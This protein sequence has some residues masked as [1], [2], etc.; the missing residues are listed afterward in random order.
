[1][2]TLWVSDSEGMRLKA[3]RPLLKPTKRWW[4]CE[5]QSRSGHWLMIILSPLSP[6]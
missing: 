6:G 5:E 2:A 1:M 3:G 4:G